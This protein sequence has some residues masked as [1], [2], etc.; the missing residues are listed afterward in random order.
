MKVAP[1]PASAIGTLEGEEIRMDLDRTAI[2]HLM[3]VLTKLYEDPEL[4]VIREY[5]TNA[6]DSHIEAGQTRPVEIRTPTWDEPTLIIQDFG[7]GMSIDDL[8]RTYSQYGASTKRD[9]NDVQGMLG[10]G[11][12]SALAYTDQ[13]TLEA[14]K[15]GVACTVVVYQDAGAP[16]LKVVDEFTT[17]EPNGVKVSIPARP[18]NQMAYKAKK[19]L[20]YWDPDHVL[21]N[22]EKPIPL[23]GI[24]VS[25]TFT[26]VKEAGPD[27]VVM[28][29]VA[30][31]THYLK[32]P[33]LKDDVHVVA[34]VGMGEVSFTPAREA[35]ELDETTNKRLIALREQFHQDL[36][37]AA[38]KAVD[39]AKTPYEAVRGALKWQHLVKYHPKITFQGKEVPSHIQVPSGTR[40]SAA[41]SEPLNKHSSRYTQV[42]PAQW[43]DSLWITNF[44]IQNYSAT[45][46][47]KSIKWA[48]QKGLDPKQF[49]Y[50]PGAMIDTEW[51]NPEMVVSW[52]EVRKIVL[53]RKASTNS[54]WGTPKDG[55]ARLKGSYDL[56]GPNGYES[57][58]P[59]EDLAKRTGALMYMSPREHRAGRSSQIHVGYPNAWIVILGDNRVNKF[60]RD[61][62]HAQYGSRALAEQ[63]LMSWFKRLKVSELYAMALNYSYPNLSDFVKR[64][65]QYERFD[66]PRFEKAIRC[67]KLNVSRHM[68]V[69]HK[70][71]RTLQY[72]GCNLPD[73]DD[74]VRND[75]PLIKTSHMDHSRLYINAVWA[76][77]QNNA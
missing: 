57:E 43:T 22:G 61:F 31:P 32:I 67:A 3:R 52:E 13:F 39:G 18:S 73:I 77:K 9:S 59:A 48:E 20:S 15:D 47:R 49:I 2:S 5:L 8:R 40:M 46:K 55:P 64:C 19:F 10:L 70:S 71:T 44:D 21:L 36:D 41:D 27:R 53:P 37:A 16:K 74:F 29:N 68:Q 7:I 50:L 63:S 69:W 33:N 75:Y 35:L 34:R 14:V 28:G 4:A 62:P 38:Q 24:K 30:Y 1:P 26:L 11:S 60:K 17:D 42:S 56:V 58:V 25:D 72:L 23:E 65:D 51:V 6:R 66:D 76:Q 12:K 54:S 45:H